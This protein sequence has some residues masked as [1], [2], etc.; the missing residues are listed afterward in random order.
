[1]SAQTVILNRKLEKLRTQYNNNVK[2]MDAMRSDYEKSLNEKLSL[3][4][5]EM[6][7]KLSEHDE[8]LRIEFEKEL[9]K[10]SSELNSELN[11]KIDDMSREY[12][13][14]KAENDEMRAQ[15]K[16]IEKEITG[17]LNSMTSR[18]DT[19]EQS[20]KNEAQSRMEKVYDEFQ[21]FSSEYPHEFFEPNAADALLMQM[22]SL[23]VDFRSG[24]YEACMASASGTG[25]QI[26]L[27]EERMKKNLEQW[28]RYF[29]QLESY[30]ALVND[31][32][33]SDDFSVISSERFE[34]K[35]QNSA[36]REAETFDFW[37]YGRYSE[38][39]EEAGKHADFTAQISRSDGNT[40]E[41]KIT[42]YL[43]SCRKKGDTVTFEDLSAKIGEV[44]ELHKK[45]CSMRVNIHTGFLSS[46]ERAAD[47]SSKIIS[48]IRDE[49]CGEILSKGFKDNDIRNEYTIIAEEPAKKIT[50]QI[51]PVCP[52]RMTVVNAVGVYFEHNGSG[53]AENLKI[54]EQNFLAGLQHITGELTVI[55]ESN[56]SAEFQDTDKAMSSIKNRA[57]EKRRKELSVRKTVR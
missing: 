11:K 15:M 25:F 37:S 52:D 38:A 53:T 6:Q 31:F 1:M 21:K 43:K 8:S 51:F 2:S 18:L 54:T 47:L 24:F 10:Y 32:L 42:S 5:K 3:M 45:V 44:T 49:R 34:K 14:L 46:F 56:C 50:V 48:W 29:S 33:V 41:E 35:L 19:R 27:L 30:T 12:A 57:N 20:M 23:K 13:Q 4:Q 39:V 7:D 40:R 16:Q 36:E 26:A 22:E 9:E 17:Q 55:S 28:T